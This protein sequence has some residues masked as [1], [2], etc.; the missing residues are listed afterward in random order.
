MIN[1]PKE[2]D[3]IFNK[4]NKYCNK[5]II[6]GGFI[7]DKLLKKDSKDIDI[8]IYGIE[9]FEILE[10]I[11]KEF[12]DVNVVGKSFG[13]CK[14]K[15][16][17][18][19]LDFSLP[20]TDSKIAPG[21]TGFDVEIDSDLDFKTATT[22]RDF[23]IN[24]IGYDVKEK[25]LLDPFGGVDDLKAKVLKAVNNT[26]FIEDPLRILRAVQF[27]ARFELK[28]DEKLFKLCQNM[29]KEN[30]LAELPK[31]R[32]FGEIKKLLLKSNKPSLG[33]ELLK[34]L[35]VLKHFSYLNKIDDLT[36]STIMSSL[37]KITKLL[38]QDDK[39]NLLLML[40]VLSYGSSQI[41]ITN[42]MSEL[43]N[44]KELA[45][46]IIVLLEN[47]ENIHDI[48]SVT[49]DNYYLY[50]LATKVSIKE[51]L[52]LNEAFYGINKDIEQRAIALDIYTKKLKPILQGK[53]L[54]KLKLTPSK[55]FSII[56]DACYDAQMREKFK[57]YD[58][59]IKWLKKY[60]A[61]DYSHLID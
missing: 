6:I 43:S 37:D 29:T 20:R 27:H 58:N 45:S 54:I 26:T 60:L 48:S 14:L 9:S 50:K 61:T 42:L 49:L 5:I 10:D 51:V 34:S 59:A 16:H 3:I 15:F 47:L 56:L 41:Q 22:R 4:L 19:D 1:Y 13:V 57:D 44:E 39:T 23:T 53:D 11:L 46:R 28:I 31:E 52:I 21:Y 36:W 33:F 55:E 8:E 18:Y 32:I 7:R 35:G 40:A 12:G 17:N 25:K 38:T 2:L 24:A 30:R